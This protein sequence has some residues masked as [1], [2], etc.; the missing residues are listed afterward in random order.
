MTIAF[1]Y[2]RSLGPVLGR[3][4]AGLRDRRVL[5]S[6]TA[7]G[8]VHVPP[9]EYDPV[10]ARPLTHNE[11]ILPAGTE[12]NDDQLDQPTE[13]F[14]SEENGGQ[15]IYLSKL[16][17]VLFAT[18]GIFG[19]MARKAELSCAT[20]HQASGQ[21]IPK[22]FPPLRASD[23]LVADRARAIRIVMSG[24]KG[25]ITVAGE[26]YSGVMPNPGLNDEQIA[27]VLSYEMTNLDNKGKPVT[28]EEVARV[29]KTWDGQSPL[30]ASAA[31]SAKPRAAR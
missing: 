11:G 30:V 20:C 9:L 16:G 7:D 1:D 24:L 2:T 26:T 15:R 27:Q 23:F 4:M 3:F 5:G 25:P 8:R 17:D 19:G 10:T 14:Y 12:L 21:G 22:V 13:L 6:R 29:R 28:V 31:W 18:P